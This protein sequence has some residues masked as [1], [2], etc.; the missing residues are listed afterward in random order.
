MEDYPKIELNKKEMDAY[1]NEIGTAQ[2]ER[3]GLVDYKS[4]L[5][6]KK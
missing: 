2:I 6:L 1:L 3:I 5:F 4:N